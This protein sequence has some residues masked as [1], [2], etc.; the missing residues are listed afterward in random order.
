M[1]FATCMAVV[2]ASAVSAQAGQPVSV[3]ALNAVGLSNVVVM[4]DAQGTQIRAKYS[5][6]AGGSTS[7]VFA[8]QSR[9]QGSGAASN[10][11]SATGK[12]NSV[13][14]NLSAAGTVTTDGNGSTSAAS[15]RAGGY[16]TV[17][18]V[19]KNNRH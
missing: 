6:T 18:N 5:F 12:N 9:S 7:V 4:S 1:K 2:F 11:A 15:A 13:Q 14:G 10:G 16:S 3:N 17:S 19:S 8:R